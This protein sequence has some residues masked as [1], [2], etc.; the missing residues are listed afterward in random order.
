MRVIAVAVAT[1]ALLMMGL[2]LRPAPDATAVLHGPAAA[3][4][5]P[6]GLQDTI[7]IKTLLEPDSAE[8]I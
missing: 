5:S 2:S 1:L 4:T 3:Q 8:L 7:N 6:Y